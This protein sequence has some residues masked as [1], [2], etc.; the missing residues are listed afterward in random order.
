MTIIQEHAGCK[1]DCALLSETLQK[2]RWRY[3]RPKR[4]GLFVT[5][6]CNLSGLRHGGTFAP[7]ARGLD[8]IVG[9]GGKWI[10]TMFSWV[11]GD[12]IDKTEE[13][14]RLEILKGLTIYSKRICTLAGIK[15]VAEN[16][17]DKA[18]IWQTK[19]QRAHDQPIS[20]EK[21]DVEPLLSVLENKDRDEMDGKLT[22][23][24]RDRL[25]RGEIKCRREDIRSLRDVLD[26]PLCSYEIPFVAHRLIAYSKWL[27]DKYQLPKDPRTATW[28]FQQV[29]MF[30]LLWYH[31]TTYV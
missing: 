30:G 2:I 28:T 13:R 10:H 12:E 25:L 15:N 23:R 21:M 18:K 19:V 29:R 22:Q 20:D 16:I 17:G 4:A 7:L 11:H 14:R 24:G 27:N 9:T 8:E 6:E 31:Q 26:L 3:D 5:L 1:D